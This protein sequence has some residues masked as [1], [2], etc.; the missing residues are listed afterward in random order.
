M[1]GR[2]MSF[3]Y[4]STMPAYRRRRSQHLAIVLQFDFN[5]RPLPRPDITGIRNLETIIGGLIRMV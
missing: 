2:L 1:P 3:T 4:D 5:P